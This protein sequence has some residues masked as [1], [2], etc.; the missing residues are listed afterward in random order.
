MFEMYE[1]ATVELFA[2]SLVGSL[3]EL[4]DAGSTVWVITT[5][6]P[7]DTLPG[8]SQHFKRRLAVP[9]LFKSD[10]DALRDSY[11]YRDALR[12]SESYGCYSPRRG[13]RFGIVAV[14][15]ANRQDIARRLAETILLDP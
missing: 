4:A 14:T 2:A 12:R 5:D 7:E 15:S 3:Q 6:V 11:P 1:E 9:R 13:T 8:E 10:I